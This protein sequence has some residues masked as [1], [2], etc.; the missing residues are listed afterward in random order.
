MSKDNDA[1][2]NSFLVGIFLVRFVQNI[3]I[4]CFFIDLR[5]EARGGAVFLLGVRHQD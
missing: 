5:I 4:H 2:L 3:A 1:I